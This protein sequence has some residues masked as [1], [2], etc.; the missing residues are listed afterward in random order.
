[1]Y[2]NRKAQSFVENK[3]KVF[4]SPY[5]STKLPITTIYVHFKE[6]Y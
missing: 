3:Q 4:V 5:I 2:N 6:N 1:M